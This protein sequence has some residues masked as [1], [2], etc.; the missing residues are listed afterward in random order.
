MISENVG[1]VLCL[2][3]DSTG[4]I[5]LLCFK[6]FSRP[7]NL[8][9]TYVH[10]T[11]ILPTSSACRERIFASWNVGHHFNVTFCMHLVTPI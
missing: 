4:T 6:G 11:C 2:G 3:Q 9:H 7:R 5:K 8:N 10:I 1:K